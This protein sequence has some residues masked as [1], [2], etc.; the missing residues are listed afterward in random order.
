[1]PFSHRAIVCFA[2]AAILS[3]TGCTLCR[4]TPSAN[5]AS[6][7]EAERAAALAAMRSV[8]DWQLTHPP[9]PKHQTYE[10]AQGAFYTGVM[11]LARITGEAKYEDAALAI[12]RT[13]NWKPGPDTYNANQ[14][15]IAQTYLELYLSH[16]DPAMI[17]DTRAGFDRVIADPKD[18]I[19]DHRRPGWIDR[20]SWCD[21]LFMG[22]P[23]WAMMTEATG[24]PKY[25][26]EMDRLWWITSD[27]LYDPAE[28]LYYR[29]NR[30]FD[31]RAANGA[32]VFWGRGNGWVVAGLARVLA[33]MPADFPNRPRYERQFQ[34]MCARLV[35]LQGSD[36]MWGTSLLDREHFPAPE[37]SGSG[38]NTFALAWGLNAGLLPGPGMGTR[39]DYEAAALRGW[40]GLVRCIQPDG[41]LGYVQAVGDRPRL[42]NPSDTEVY[43]AGA[44]LLAGSEIIPLAERR[45]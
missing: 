37:S 21:A 29:D 39:A 14:Q 36:G 44:F 45:Q 35:E 19:L 20:W 11:A 24:D 5:S 43:G 26:A 25:L 28:R 16:R 15:C 38:F 17:A 18:T 30:Y 3:I 41:M 33:H 2:L 10:W 34:E 9:L 40:V 42:V 32:K 31:Q 27:Y 8:A 7:P 6:P 12:G 1:M 23:A 13:N 4:L 22:P